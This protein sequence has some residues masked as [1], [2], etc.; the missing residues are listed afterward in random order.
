MQTATNL[1]AHLA[2]FVTALEEKLQDAYNF[3][4]TDLPH[5]VVEEG[6]KYYKVIQV[7]SSRDGHRRSVHCFVEKGTLN[8]LKAAG[9][10]APAKGVRYNLVKDYE[11]LMQVVDPY[12]SYLYT[13]F[14]KEHANGTA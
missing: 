2:F 3:D 10:N 4:P 14:I 1:P 5:V 11:L 13:S 9:W 8:L 12:G 6:R 7:G